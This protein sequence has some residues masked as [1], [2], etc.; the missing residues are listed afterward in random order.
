MQ[1]DT[2]WDIVRCN[3]TYYGGLALSYNKKE[4]AV[5]CTLSE[6]RLRSVKNL[7]ATYEYTEDNSRNILD[8]QFVAENVNEKWLTDV[9]GFRC[10]NGEKLYINVILNLK[11]NRIV[12]GRNNNFLVFSSSRLAVEKYP[13]AVPIFHSDYRLQYTIKIFKDKL[14]VVIFFT[15]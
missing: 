9:T 11:D 7:P 5:L 1:Q 4:C 12:F 3:F 13:D 14:E 2:E 15:N 10:D 8:R 6:R